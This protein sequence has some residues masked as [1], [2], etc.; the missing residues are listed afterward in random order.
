MMRLALILLIAATMIGAL[1]P[2]SPGKRAPAP[3]DGI[4]YTPQATGSSYRVVGSGGVGAP[5]P[6]A[7]FGG[8]LR[9]P[10]EADGHFYVTAKV[11]GA[12]IRF[13]V[14]TGATSVA[15]TRSD[16]QRA[17]LALG[18]LDQEIGSGASGMVRGQWVTLDS[19]EVGPRTANAVEAAVLA[20]GDQSLLGQS[21]LRQFGS[22]EMVRD[23]MVLR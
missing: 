2:S 21:V 18:A 5:V 8:T 12:P 22:I 1:M 17:G 16:A 3:A 20:G 9:L 7:G 19:V 11:N 23:E 10:R 14:D 15:L 13:L 4:V 6:T